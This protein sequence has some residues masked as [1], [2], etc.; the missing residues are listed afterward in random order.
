MHMLTKATVAFAALVGALVFV[1]RA[2]AQCDGTEAFCAS[3]QVGGSFHAHARV[4]APR[5]AQ[6]VV[7]DPGPPPPPPPPAP[8][9]VIVQPE[10]PPPPPQATVIVTTEVAPPPAPVVQV[11]APQRPVRP[12]R[13]G[14]HP[15][16][17]GVFGDSVNMGG[18]RLGLR[19]RP[20]NG[21]FAVDVGGGVFGGEDYN[22][23]TRREI[24]LTLDAVFFINPQNRF[25]LYT[26][27]GLGVSWAHTDDGFNVR[28]LEDQG[29]RDYTHFGG[30]VGLGLE[31]RLSRRF[32]LNVDARGF[33]RWRVDDNPTPEFR[34]LD[35]RST[36]TSGGVTGNF[37]MTFY[38]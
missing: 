38:W 19:F 21:H 2:Q 8:P 35:G 14:F 17:G 15:Q 10:Q 25:Q 4:G 3:V 22:G 33:L 34:E 30:E 36:D 1:P 23:L 11:T 9:V 5:S 31:W 26:L 18:V 28:T 27:A 32:A 6:V 16:V 12:T 37:G 7:V 20:N 29:P 13:M 24:P